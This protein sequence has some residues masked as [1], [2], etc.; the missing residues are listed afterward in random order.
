MILILGKDIKDN[1]HS[2][3]VGFSNKRNN[4]Y[5]LKSTPAW[6]PRRRVKP[7]IKRKVCTR[8]NP[9]G[10]AFNLVGKIHKLWVNRA[11]SVEGVQDMTKMNDTGRV[12]A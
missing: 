5:F 2:G 6:P 1:R 3:H 8:S 11:S 10:M 4:N 12:F 9:C 7:A